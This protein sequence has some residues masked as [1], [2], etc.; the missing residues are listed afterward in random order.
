[1]YNAWYVVSH[2]SMLFNIITI[3]NKKKHDWVPIV[4]WWVKDMTQCLWGCRFHLWPRSELRIWR[5]RELW[6]R[7]QILFRFSV[8]VAVAWAGSCSSELDSQTGNF[9]MLQVWPSKEKK[10]IMT[11]IELQQCKS[12]VYGAPNPE[13]LTSRDLWSW[14]NKNLHKKNL[15]WIYGN[16]FFLVKKTCVM[17]AAW[18]F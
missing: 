5:C 6:H 10:K 8:A 15:L 12:Q 2:C 3:V 17:L 4:A 7:S 16:F 18:I 11:N 9:H 13:Q 14:H 1:M